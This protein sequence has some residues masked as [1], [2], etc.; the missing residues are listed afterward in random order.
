MD[1][2]RIGLFLEDK[3]FERDLE[4]GLSCQGP[5]LD[6]SLCHEDMCQG[7]DIV[8]TDGRVSLPGEQL[9]VYLTD[10]IEQKNMDEMTL[11]K[12]QGSKSLLDDLLFLY[13]KSEGRILKQD[14]ENK[15][16]VIGICSRNSQRGV[17]SI[18]ITLAYHFNVTMDMETLY[19][20]IEPINSSLTYLAEGYKDEIKLL[21][22]MVRKG[23]TVDLSR[24]ISRQDEIEYFKGSEVNYLSIFNLK[25]LESV[26]ELIKKHKNYKVIILDMG[27]YID[28]YSRICNLI[29][30]IGKGKDIENMVDFQ[31][32]PGTIKAVHFDNEA[33]INLDDKRKINWHSMFSLDVKGIAKEVANGID[34]VP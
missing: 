19:F 18:A 14:N 29:L 10:D 4:K 32:E 27:T 13:S 23:L 20:N 6:I 2:I 1:S 33:F 16:Y 22:Y 24:Y 28:D 30:E 5:R 11:F 21:M 31:E 12:Y 15:T 26:L 8:V 17:T 34:K 25:E 7:Y 3:P 9:V